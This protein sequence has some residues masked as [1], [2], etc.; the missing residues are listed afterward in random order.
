MGLS[1]QKSTQSF[2]LLDVKCNND[3]I[4]I[5]TLYIFFPIYL[6]PG[7]IPQQC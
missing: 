2:Y 7:M 4:I 5:M 3:I 6:V 1:V